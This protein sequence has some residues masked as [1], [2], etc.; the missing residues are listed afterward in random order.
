MYVVR[1]EEMMKRRRQAAAN[2]QIVLLPAVL[3]EFY[4]I[5]SRWSFLT[6]Y[7]FKANTL[8]F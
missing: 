3:L 6:V 7:Y 5:L 2:Y 1:G 4:N 8:P